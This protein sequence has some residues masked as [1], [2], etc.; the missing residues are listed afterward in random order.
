VIIEF[1]IDHHGGRIE[2]FPPGVKGAAR[3]AVLLAMAD[4]G[5]VTTDGTQWFVAA[6]GYDAVGRPRQPLLRPDP[7]DEIERAMALMQAVWERNNTHPTLHE[8][9]SGGWYAQYHG[10]K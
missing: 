4:H 9:A 7:F 10:T 1:A 8:P 6:A 5:L 3:N 2:W